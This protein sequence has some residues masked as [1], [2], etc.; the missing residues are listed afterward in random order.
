MEWPEG[1]RKTAARKGKGN[2][3]EVGWGGGCQE[4]PLCNVRTPGWGRKTESAAAV[5]WVG[6]CDG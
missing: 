5:C 1:R 6:R 2:G 4:T 3:T